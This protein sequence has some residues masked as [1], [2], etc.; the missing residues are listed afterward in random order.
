MKK[1]KTLEDELP[2][3]DKLVF[4]LWYDFH[5]KKMIHN[6]DEAVHFN[7]SKDHDHPVMF[8]SY[9]THITEDEIRSL[10][11]SADLLIL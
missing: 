4:V 8:W 2:E 1:F 9:E 6:V 7:W 10:S 3:D 5:T 11:L